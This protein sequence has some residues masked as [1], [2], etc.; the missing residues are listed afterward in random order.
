MDKVGTRDNHRGEDGACPVDG[1]GSRIISSEL[2]DKGADKRVA[3]HP[4]VVSVW[5][6]GVKR[7]DS[8][9]VP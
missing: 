6:R 8:D 4:T 5:V 7:R 1:V 3:A 9:R 2:A